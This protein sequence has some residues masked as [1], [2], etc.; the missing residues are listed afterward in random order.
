METHEIKPEVKIEI[1]RYIWYTND[2]N[3]GNNLSNC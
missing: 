1:M 3:D 2:R